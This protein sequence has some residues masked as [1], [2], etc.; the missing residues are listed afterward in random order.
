MKAVQFSLKPFDSVRGCDKVITPQDM[1]Y[2]VIRY[3]D[4]IYFGQVITK[5]WHVF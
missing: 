4:I 1:G 3:H 5:G 2:D